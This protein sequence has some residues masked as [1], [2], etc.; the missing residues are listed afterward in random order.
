MTREVKAQVIDSLTAFI[1]ENANI[2]LADMSGLDAQMTSELRRSCF[3]LGISL[4]VVKNTLL[5]IAMDN[6]DRDFEGMY[7]ALKGNTSIMFSESAKAPAKVIKE[8]G[9]KADK[10]TLKA[11]YVEESIYIGHDQL[12]TLVSIK[13]KEEVIGDVIELLQ[14]P[15]KSVISALQSG[16]DRLS[17]IIKVLSEKED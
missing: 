8:F 4:T 3:E 17:G 10:L 16:R 5:K 13:S 6:S 7:G 1:N 12:D 14:S 11:A 9:K 15:A 2:Y